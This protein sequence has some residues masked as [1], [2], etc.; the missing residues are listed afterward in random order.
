MPAEIYI[1]YNGVPFC[2]LAANLIGLGYFG[3]CDCDMV[4]DYVHGHR[5]WHIKIGC[6]Q[7]CSCKRFTSRMLVN[8][9]LSIG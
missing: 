8:P 5:L 6:E 7:R 1:T 2:I 4:I 3:T 9:R